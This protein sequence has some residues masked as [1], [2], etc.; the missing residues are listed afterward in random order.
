[1]SAPA[2]A[3]PLLKVAGLEAWYGESH[4]LHGVGF[5][6]GRGE[7]V[8]LLGRNGAGKTT[9]LKSVMGIVE[10]RRGSVT[11]DGQ[12]TIG[13]A[14]NAITSFVYQSAPG[15][16]ALAT[17]GIGLGAVLHADYSVVDE[18]HPA[19]PEEVVQIFLTGLGDVFPTIADGAPGGLETLNHTVNQMRASVAGLTA[20]VFYAGLAPTFSGLYQMNIKVPA[21]TPSGNQVLGVGGPDAFS[22][23]IVIPIAP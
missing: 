11:F 20:D 10:R 15:I 7:L 16:F 6:I 3:D 5:E 23:Q 2:M 21:G 12:E 13:Q 19:H 18:A 22:S 4:I 14:S 17:N 9:T 8:T 1:M